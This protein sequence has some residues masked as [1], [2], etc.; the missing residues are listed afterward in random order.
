M[1]FLVCRSAHPRIRSRRARRGARRIAIDGPAPERS[2]PRAA[3]IPV[4]DPIDAIGWFPAGNVSPPFRRPAHPRVRGPHVERAVGTHRRCVEVLV[5]PDRHG[6]RL[7][8]NPAVGGP[9]RP[10]LFGGAEVIQ[11]V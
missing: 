8:R 10:H 7:P 5:V 6:S 9:G 1:C 11:I 4:A 2:C 3:A